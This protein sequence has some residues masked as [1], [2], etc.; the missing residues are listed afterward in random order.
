MLNFEEKESKNK[1]C[2]LTGKPVL[3]IGILDYQYSLGIQ[4][5][6][7]HSQKLRMNHHLSRI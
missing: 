1:K 2:K 4:V 3:H 7:R 6:C 5:T